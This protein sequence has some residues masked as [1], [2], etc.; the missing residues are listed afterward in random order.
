[1]R[2]IVTALLLL[3][4]TLLKAQTSE[5]I[6]ELPAVPAE[7]EGFTDVPKVYNYVEDMPQFPGGERAMLKFLSDSLVY[8]TLEKEKGMEGKVFVKF[9]VNEDGSISDVHVTRS[10]S[11]G[12][13]EEALRVIK[14]M[15][16]FS[17]G[18]KDG[19]PV[20][21]YYIIPIYFQLN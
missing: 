6:K 8:P 21:V 1:M 11:P 5:Q 3:C 20:R 10:V 19:K 16:K 13:D 12:L 15:P 17:P 4:C 7:D 14:M 9:I 18:M 2:I